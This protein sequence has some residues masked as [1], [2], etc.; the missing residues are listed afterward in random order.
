MFFMPRFVPLAEICPS[1]INPPLDKKILDSLFVKYFIV[2]YYTTKSAVK[3]LKTDGT[4]CF[5]DLAKL[6]LLMVVRF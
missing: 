5:R 2:L 6:N 3:T 1:E 4:V